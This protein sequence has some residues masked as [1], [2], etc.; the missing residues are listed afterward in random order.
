MFVM[1]YLKILMG[2]QV[3]PRPTTTVAVVRSTGRPF[4]V[5]LLLQVIPVSRFLTSPFRD[6]GLPP[7]LSAPAEARLPFAH[8]SCA[9][10]LR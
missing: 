6:D 5:L 1:F 7:S 4:L 9:A 2:G 10:L 3:I 8:S